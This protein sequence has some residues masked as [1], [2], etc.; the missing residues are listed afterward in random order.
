IAVYDH[1]FPSDA[2]GRMAPFGIYDT[3]ANHGFVWA[4]VATSN[5]PTCGRVKL[6]HRPRRRTGWKL[7]RGASFGSPCG[8]L[9]QSPALALE[10]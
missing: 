7:M 3:Q 9:L 6:P 2:R 5:S 8:G 4:R 1:D 10:A